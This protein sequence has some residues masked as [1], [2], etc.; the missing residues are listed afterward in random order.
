M[1]IVPA[2]SGAISA[3]AT[4]PAQLILD[5]SGFFGLFPY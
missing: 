2:N 4:D 3:F 5:L 1:A